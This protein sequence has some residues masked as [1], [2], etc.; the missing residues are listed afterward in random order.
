VAVEDAENWNIFKTN[1]KELKLRNGTF[2]PVI[3]CWNRGKQNWEMIQYESSQNDDGV[4]FIMCHG[5]MGQGML[6]HSIGLPIELYGKSKKF[7]LDNCDCVEVE[8]Y[9]GQSTARRW[10]RVYP[11]EGGWEDCAAVRR[12]FGGDGL[13]CER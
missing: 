4:V 9:D 1:P 3:D 6:L 8:W 13:G 11:K 7:A 2:Y 12:M 5:A 10:R